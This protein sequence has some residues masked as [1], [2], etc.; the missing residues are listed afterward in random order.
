MKSIIYWFSGT[1]NSLVVAMDLAKTLGGRELIPIAGIINRTIQPCE[2]MLVV[3]PV[4][5]FGLPLIVCR[6]LQSAP[7]NKAKY[8]YTVATMGGIA[9]AVHHEADKIL[10]GQGAKLSAGWSI[11]MPGN[12]PVLSAPPKPAKQTLLFAKAEKRIAEIT[13]AISDGKTGIYEDT[14]IPLR[15]PLEFIH[16]LAGNKFP[17]ADENFAVGPKCTHCGLCAKVCPVVNIRMAEGNPVW[18]HHCEQCMACLQWC[19][20]Q[21]IE[22]GKSTVG[23]PRYHHPRFKAK[24]L[25]LREE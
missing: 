6:F 18:M 15:W 9:G 14:R 16:N 10:S 19:P 12:Y 17:D 22:Y 3:F 21:A 23:K 24:D 20:V 8:I 25:F 11:S 2:Q 5:A 7:V 1:G 13:A 4:Y